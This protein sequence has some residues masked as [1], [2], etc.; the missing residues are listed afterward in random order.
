MYIGL[1]VV[2]LLVCLLQG[3]ERVV[4]VGNYLCNNELS[5]RMLAYAMDYWSQGSIKGLFLRHEGYFGA[6][7]SMLMKMEEISQ[8]E[9]ESN[10]GEESE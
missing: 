4:F 1:N 9:S 5:T 2:C 7:G 10:D 3:V 8:I 6:I